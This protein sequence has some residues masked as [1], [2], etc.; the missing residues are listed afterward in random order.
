MSSFKRQCFALRRSD[1]CHWRIAVLRRPVV[2]LMLA[3]AA[4]GSPIR[5]R[6]SHCALVHR[7]DRCCS[8]ARRSTV[9]PVAAGLRTRRPVRSQWC[10]GASDG[11][12]RSS[13]SRLLVRVL[14]PWLAP[15]S[16][17][18]LHAQKSLL[19]SGPRHQSGQ[20]ARGNNANRGSRGVEHELQPVPGHRQEGNWRGAG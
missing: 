1:G 19:G 12:S 20:G 8:S 10:C 17:E 2:P 13:P 18:V 3:S 14:V 5:R 9:F 7:G 16:S 11:S 6:W 15:F 4:P